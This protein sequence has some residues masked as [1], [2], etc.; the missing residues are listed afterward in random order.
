MVAPGEDI[1]DFAKV[2]A[3]TDRQRIEQG[4]VEHPMPDD[5]TGGRRRGIRYLKGLQYWKYARILS[6]RVRRIG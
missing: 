3:E 6:G 5:A 4:F 2:S 1:V